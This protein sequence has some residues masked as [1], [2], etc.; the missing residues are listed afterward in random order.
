[1]ACIARRDPHSPAS[2]QQWELPAL[3]GL[4]TLLMARRVCCGDDPC[5][6]K[7]AAPRSSLHDPSLTH[8][9]V[10]W[11]INV[12]RSA[13]SLSHSGNLI[14]HLADG[15]SRFSWSRRVVCVTGGDGCCGPQ[16]RT[17]TLVL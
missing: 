6:V 10:P 3:S 5:I 11:R 17:V 16:L 15:G 13:P 2:S 8:F 14:A 4:G 12:A 9:A 1:M 7:A